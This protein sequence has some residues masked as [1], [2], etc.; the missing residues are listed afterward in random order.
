MDSFIASTAGPVSTDMP[1]HEREIL[2][3]VRGA[4]IHKVTKDLC[5]SASIHMINK[6]HQAR[7]KYKCF[8]LMQSLRIPEGYVKYTD[9]P[10]SLKEISR[11]QYNTRGLTIVSDEAFTF[12][13]YVYCK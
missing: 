11:R 8:Q 7:I 4:T 10:A 9:D 2:R 3:H 1:N 12:F 6:M 13:K 5:T